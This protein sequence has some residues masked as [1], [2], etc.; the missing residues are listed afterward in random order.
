MPSLGIKGAAW[1]TIADF[2]VAALLNM[3]FVYRYFGFAL[4]VKDTLKTSAAAAVMGLVCL[5][6][7]ELLFAYGV[8]NTVSTLAAIVV[9]GGVY[10]V[11]LLLVGG[12][13]ERELAKVPKIGPPVA[14]FL[15]K[16]HLLRR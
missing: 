16:I 1:A 7:Y 3:F 14:V 13:G 4:D 5:G 10:A 12:I 15:K 9:G 8:G 2:G 6:L 11:M